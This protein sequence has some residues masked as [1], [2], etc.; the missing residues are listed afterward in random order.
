MKKSLFSTSIS[1]LGVFSTLRPLGVISMV[2]PDRSKFVTLIVKRRSLMMAGDDDELFMIR[3]LNVTPKTTEQHLIVRSGKSE[4][5]PTNNRRVRWRYCTIEANY[6]QTRSIARP[7]PLCDSR[8]TWWLRDDMADKPGWHIRPPRT[9]NTSLFM[10]L[11][12][13]VKTKNYS[14]SI[15]LEIQRSNG[16][17]KHHLS[18]TAVILAPFTSILTYLL[19][20]HYSAKAF[21]RRQHVCRSPHC[22]TITFS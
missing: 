6:W 19:S 12:M 15:E 3:S 2:T 21:S 1:L 9:G 4:A 13:K 8:A 10:A 7:R 22:I 5:K 17:L 11:K 16:S 14:N 18:G 20:L